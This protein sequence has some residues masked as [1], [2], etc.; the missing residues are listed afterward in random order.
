MHDDG[1]GGISCI[2]AEGDEGSEGLLASPIFTNN[3]TDDN[4]GHRYERREG[5]AEAT[6]VA[7]KHLV[8]ADGKPMSMQA[9]QFEFQLVIDDEVIATATN[10][11]DGTVSFPT[12]YYSLGDIG[13][14]YTYL[15]SEVVPED[16]TMVADG[17]WVKDGVFYDTHVDTYTVVIGWNPDERKDRRTERGICQRR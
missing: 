2:V 9:G 1:V 13:R 14:T 11:A 8:D 12:M 16:A 5:D 15:I 4:G 10:E 7:H 6:P 17:I 3:Q